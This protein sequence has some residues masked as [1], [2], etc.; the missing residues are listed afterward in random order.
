[1]NILEPYLDRYDKVVLLEVAEIFSLISQIKLLDMI[2]QK[3]M[4]LSSDFFQSQFQNISF[5]QV[6]EGE[7][8]EL[9]ELYFTYEFS[10]KFFFI[11]EN[12]INYANLH[13]MVDMGILSPE[14]FFAALLS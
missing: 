12:N 14:E 9:L 10:D 11:S 6:S 7:F 1:M 5:I 8:Q 3:I 4:I 2:D 13:H